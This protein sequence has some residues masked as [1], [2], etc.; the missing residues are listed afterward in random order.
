MRI[1]LIELWVDVARRRR[2][3][4]E[5][6]DAVAVSRA[7]RANP[8]ERNALALR[9]IELAGGF[10]PAVIV[11][12]GWTFVGRAPRPAT[13]ARAAGK[14]A[15][16]YE[17]LERGGT[18]RR[19]RGKRGTAGPDAGGPDLPWRPHALEGGA[20]RELPGQA[21][22][23]SGELDDA[24]SRSPSRLAAALRDGRRVGSAVVLVCAEVNAVR[25]VVQA[26]APVRHVWDERMER[27]GALERDLAGALV[28]NPSH[29][30]AG[31]YVREKRRAGPWRALVSTAN[32]LDRTR[33]G[34]PALAPP[35]HA[36]VDG[37]D[38]EPALAPVAV[39]GRGS[40]V[41]L[42]D[43]ALG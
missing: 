4:R 8:G 14:A 28:L 3:A 9:A 6:S 22:L 13:L 17:V 35:A 36:V 32:A 37:R 10:D 33:L 41:V 38:Q 31:S 23:S 42:H 26:G 40:R 5:V 30:P 1:A 11:C 39:D 20:L 27:A 2:T 29:T 34:R 15:L 24:G 16:L 21:F 18:R 7:L 19:A 25:R 43:L 12:P